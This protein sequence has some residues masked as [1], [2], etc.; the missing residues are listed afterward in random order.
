[1]Q[2][3]IAAAVVAALKAEA[4][5]GAGK[6]ATDR[7]RNTEAYNQY[8][9]GRHFDL[10]DTSM[11]FTA[12]IDTYHKAIA[13]DPGYAAAYAGLA[14]AE[15]VRR[16][17]TRRCGGLQASDGGGGEGGHPRTAR[18][19]RLRG[20]RLFATERQPDWS[21]ADSGLEKALA[22]DPSDN[23]SGLLGG[24]AGRHRPVAGGNRGGKKAS[25][26]DPLI[27]TAWSNSGIVSASP[28]DYPAAHEA[29]RRALEI[30]P[31]RL[32]P[33]PDLG[34]LLLEGNAAAALAMCRKIGIEGF[35]LSG[36]RMAEHSLGHAKQSQQASTS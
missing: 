12:P 8:L 11:A 4:R 25:E 13:L 9:L 17:S 22:L 30:S 5:A 18:V 26:I 29:L 16:R 23:R 6:S 34:Q 32:L 10:E 15:D 35:R 2:D 14:F 1:M 20:A 31:T 21:G 19:R 28:T 3:E 33:S 24:R 7:S 27:G 36:S